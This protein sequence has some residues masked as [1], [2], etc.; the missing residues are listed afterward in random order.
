MD[1]Q[2]PLL[3]QRVEETKGRI[4]DYL[5]RDHKTSK[6]VRSLKRITHLMNVIHVIS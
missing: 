2:A 6:E 5:L 3:V 4:E 1:Y